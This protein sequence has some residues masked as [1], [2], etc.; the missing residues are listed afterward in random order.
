MNRARGRKNKL[1]IGPGDVFSREAIPGVPPFELTC[2]QTAGRDVVPAAP[3]ADAEVS[4]LCLG[5]AP[6]TAC[7][8]IPQL[9]CLT[10]GEAFRCQGREAFPE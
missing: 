6:S 3:G 2:G 5:S 9:F 1:E 10:W 8:K 7:T 4:H